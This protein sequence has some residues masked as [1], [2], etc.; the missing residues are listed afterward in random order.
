[1]FQTI[2]IQWSKFISDKNF[3]EIF[4]GSIWAFGAQIVSTALAMLFNIL[5]ARLF[6]ANVLGSVAMIVSFLSL[7][8]IF[9]VIGTNTSI[10]RLIPEHISRYSSSSA[11]QVYRKVLW[12]VIGISVVAGTLIFIFS[13]FIA[14]N[15]FSKPHLTQL[16]ALSAIF[17]PFAAISDLN[18]HTIRGIKLIRSFA[19]M[20]LL[21]A[22]AKFSILAILCL[23]TLRSS[24]PFYA[25]FSSYILTAVIGIF[26][27]LK[28]FHI[29]N[30]NDDIIHPVSLKY[31]L[32]LSLPMFMTSAMSFFIGQVGL[33]ILGMFRSET[34]VG[35]YDIAVKLASLTTF[36][37]G[38]VN[39][40]AAPK[41][42]ELY[43]KGKID[44]L[45]DLARKTSKMIFW[46]TFPLLLILSMG[47]KSILQI[48]FGRDFVVAYIALLLLVM[49]QFVNSISGSVGY[50]MNMTGNQTVFRNIIFVGALLNISFSWILIPKFGIN[51]AAAATTVSLIFWNIATL[52]FIKVK[53]GKI[54]GYFPGT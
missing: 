40:M 19:F 4:K 15:F 20:Q 18:L 25:L 34:E 8:T 45:L 44:E 6:G 41:F 33:L 42:S 17:L 28:K 27:L 37:L 13:N 39:A 14:H 7:A 10:L 30:A 9:T 23:F 49:G 12:L 31:I 2:K 26:I 29:N 50:F 36:I 21:P 3:A 5:I 11:F 22:L 53:Y 54:I 52:I 32:T 51:G 48:L 24:I 38:A 46:L 47:G 35:Y 1:M 43:S 16:F